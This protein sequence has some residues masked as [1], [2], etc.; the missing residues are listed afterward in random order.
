MTPEEQAIR[1]K[2]EAL[3]ERDPVKRAQRERARARDEAESGLVVHPNARKYVPPQT[4]NDILAMKWML[5]V[6]GGAGAGAALG[7]VL[8]YLTYATNPSPDSWNWGP[9]VQGFIFAIIGASIGALTGPV[10]V[11]LVSV[12]RKTPPD[13]SADTSNALSA[14]SEQSVGDDGS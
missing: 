5:A 9:R 7:W 2:R 4:P 8:G 14:R 1:D 11:S 10:L 3:A 13:S 6:Y 12:C